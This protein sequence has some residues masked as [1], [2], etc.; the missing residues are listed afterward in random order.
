VDVV[1]LYAEEGGAGL[2]LVF[3]FHTIS[4]PPSQLLLAPVLVARFI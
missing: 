3:C 1:V 4:A 2:L